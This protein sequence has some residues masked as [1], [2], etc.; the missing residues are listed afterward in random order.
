MAIV[1]S[2]FPEPPFREK[3]PV[4]QQQRLQA[5]VRREERAGKKRRTHQT[6]AYDILQGTNKHCPMPERSCKTK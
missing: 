1:N 4:S 5:P 6:T 2:N 3:E